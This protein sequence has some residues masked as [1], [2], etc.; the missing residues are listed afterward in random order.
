MF[1]GNV[2]EA[3]DFP[4]ILA[5]FDLLRH[6]PDIKLVVLGDGRAA[7]HVRS[8]I[9]RR[10]LS[11]A[12]IM[13]GK[14]P[15]ERMPAFFRAADALLVSLKPE[16]IYAMT[17]P[18]KVQAYLAAGIPLLGMIDG[19]GAQ[20]IDESGAGFACPAGDGAALARIIE[21]LAGMSLSDREAM[22]RRGRE[23]GRREFDREMLIDRLVN[24][25][26]DAASRSSNVR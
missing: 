5:A 18:G 8:E 26:E 24:W 20:V 16:P 3:Q 2:G 6:R 17:I 19:E 14:Y 23:Y 9:I 12:V 1:A 22:G 13:L 4:A 11:N 25:L 15:L 10:G 21:R 7:E